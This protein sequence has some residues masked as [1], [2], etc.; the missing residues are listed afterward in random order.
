MDIHKTTHAAIAFPSDSPTTARYTSGLTIYDEALIGGRWIGRYWSA[1]SFIEPER[2]LKWIEPNALNPVASMGLDAAAF[3]LE[4]ESQ[5]LHFGWEMLKAWQEPAARAEQVHGVVEL[6]STLIPLTVQVHT[7]VDGTGFLT[8]WLTITNHAARPVAMGHVSPLS[9]ILARVKD[10][11]ALLGGD[12][13]A[14]VFS[15]GYMT[16]RTWG[17]EGAFAWQPL[18]STALRIESRTGKSGHG[19]P[20]FMVRNEA[21][22]EYIV[23]G[24]AWSGNWAVELTC[25]QNAGPDAM[26]AFHAGPA[27]RAPQRVIEAGET[28]TTPKIHLGVLE[29]DFDGAI[30][31]WHRHLR[32]SVLRA[33]PPEGENRVLYNHWSYHEHE[34]TEERLKLEIDV[35]TQLGAEVFMVD[36]G[37]FGNIGT[38]WWRTVGDWQCGDRLPNGLEPIFAYAR[39]NGMRCGMWFDLE[40]IGD[41][42]KVAAAHPEWRLQSYGRPTEG[43]DMDLTNPE[44]IAHLERTLTGI[45]D[46]Y[47]LEVFRLDYNTQPFEG[48]QTLRDGRMENTLWR[49]YENVY[50]L[51]DRIA[52]RYPNMLFENCAGGGGRTDIGLLG[53]FHY[54]WV[55]DWQIAPRTL[56]ILNG[57]SMA[58]PPERIDRNAGVGQ[59]GHQRAD[60]DFQMR[61]CM[62]GHFTLTGIYPE[63]GTENPDMLQRIRHH[64]DTYKQ[65]IRPFLSTC[66]LYH[67]T[68]EIKSREPQGWCV[69]EQVAEDQSRAMVGLFRLAGQADDTYTLQ[70]RGVDAG[71]RYKLTFDNTG[72]TTVMSGVELLYKGLT[73][74][75]ARSLTSELILLESTNEG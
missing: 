50:A 39:Q 46:R 6:H 63:A 73:V 48:G 13:Q 23:G 27:G 33:Y 42:S 74:R 17:N 24:I 57:M 38:N 4:I 68:P 58:L 21:T 56:R 65:F 71:R 26:L 69:L 10:W 37:W 11:Q 36:A 35:A 1:K 41:Q 20:F 60:L 72:Q 34:L 62:F 9:G 61:V 49:Y 54:T 3:E 66:R 22:G 16:E 18:P 19:N 15:A 30:Q 14:A 75:L 52:A 40:R 31:A 47:G 51:Y 67:H 53:K 25:E 32:Q 59:D 5:S 2:L 7:E 43:G 64:V 12:S 8:R 70:L 55:S 28:I 29:T 44:A 45:I